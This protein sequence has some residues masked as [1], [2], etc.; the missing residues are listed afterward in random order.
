MFLKAA[1]GRE[2]Y[3]FPD[4]SLDTLLQ[5]YTEGRCDYLKMDIEG[6]EYEVLEQAIEN[7]SLVNVQQLAVEFHHWMT[8]RG[9]SATKRVVEMLRRDG[10]GIAWI[11]RTNHEYLF[12]R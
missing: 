11:S 8:D 9:C 3:Y 5:C 10:Y 1:I 12:V 6:S 7:N 4:V 2:P